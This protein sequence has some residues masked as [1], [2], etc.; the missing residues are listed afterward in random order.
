MYLARKIIKGKHHFFIRHS[1]R[2]GDN[3]L[4]RDLFDLGDNPAKYIIYPGGNSFYFDEIIADRLDALG[5]TATDDELEDIFWR[6]LKSDIQRALETFR[7]REK[8]SNRSHLAKDQK[9]PATDYHI[10]DRRRIH[11]LKFGRMDQRGL[12]RLPVKLFDMLQYKSRD[13]IEQKFIDM[14]NVLRP[15]EYKAYT[16]VIF[17]IQNFF[18]EYYAKETPQMLDQQK[19]DAYFID[20]ICNLNTDIKFW[21]GM[22][23]GDGLHEYL[24]RYA[25]M[26]FDYEYASKSFIE[27]YIR[28]FMDSRRDYHPAYHT[29][30]VTLGEA[31]AIFGKTKSVLKEMSRHSLAR[32]YRRHAQKLHPDKGGD[33]DKF[34][35]LSRAYHDLLKTKKF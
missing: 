6:F 21:D 19:V 1:Y 34:V 24:T 23:A 15:A 35:K 2:N 31:S 4:S 3:Y 20:E 22:N 30:S 9:I 16:Y 25:F 18:S 26:Y 8:R 29:S 7:R 27:E 33:H 5:A 13:E 28:N 14:E 17:N 11:F 32:L 10:F 12:A